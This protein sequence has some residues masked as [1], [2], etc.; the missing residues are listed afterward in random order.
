MVWYAAVSEAGFSGKDVC[1][2]EGRKG[3]LGTWMTIPQLQY[4]ALDTFEVSMFE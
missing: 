3:M 2:E 4:A 1:E